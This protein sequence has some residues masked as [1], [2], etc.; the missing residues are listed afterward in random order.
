MK[1]KEL[2]S[3]INLTQKQLAEKMQTT[4]QTVARWESGKTVLNVDQIRDLCLVLQCTADELL[5]WE[6]D[7]SD[8]SASPF[9]AV[10]SE[11]P[12]GTLQI[13]TTSLEREY[14]IGEEARKSLLSQ[15][16][17]F[18]PTSDGNPSAWLHT[19]TLNNKLLLINPAYLATFRLIS[20]DVEAMPEFENVEVYRALEDWPDVAVTGK[21]RQACDEV[22]A[23]LGSE[24]EV[25]RLVSET[26]VTYS[27]GTVNWYRLSDETATAWYSAIMA[28]D[29]IGQKSF[30]QIDEVG[31][32]D[33][34]FA[35]LGHVALVEIPANLFFRLTSS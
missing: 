22:A 18:D 20:D 33:V 12:F 25:F 35:N 10:R 23:K 17:A 24:E 34:M 30:V 11:L 5:G 7:P 28:L 4:Q 1:L 15:M 6:T 16:D 8:I 13:K 19:W 27:D 31:N 29:N 9:S 26:C 3:R 14:P 21:T 2:R 32:Y